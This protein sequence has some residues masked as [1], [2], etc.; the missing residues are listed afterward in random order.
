LTAS[1]W[2]GALKLLSSK[3]PPPNGA[4]AEPA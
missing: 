3:K 2:G 4:I 1:V